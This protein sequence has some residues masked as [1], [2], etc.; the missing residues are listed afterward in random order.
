MRFCCDLHHAKIS[1]ARAA[2]LAL[3]WVFIVG[4][5]LFRETAPQP[6]PVELLSALAL[7]FQGW[8]NVGASWIAPALVLS[9]ASVELSK[10]FV[11]GQS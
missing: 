9:L 5:R 4:I 6:L 8:K 10:H 7:I 3:V 1:V 2:G 11:S